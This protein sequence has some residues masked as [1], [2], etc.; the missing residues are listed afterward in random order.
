MSN[1]RLRAEGWV[2][3]VTNEQ[4]FVEGTNAKWWTMLTPKRKQ[5]ISLGV[6]SVAA[7]VIVVTVLLSL[8]KFRRQRSEVS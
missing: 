2:P 4:A 3:T 5:E 8:R 6:M 1:G 7:V